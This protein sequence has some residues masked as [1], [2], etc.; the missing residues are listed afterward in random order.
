[1][2]DTCAVVHLD[3]KPRNVVMVHED[4]GT[5]WKLIDMDAA[6]RMGSLTGSTKT[7][8]A[9]C[10]PEIIRQKIAGPSGKDFQQQIDQKKSELLEAQKEDDYLTGENLCRELA[11]LQA[12]KNTV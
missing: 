8:T 5:A 3:T 10:S 6:N 9:Y 1:M 11:N 12:R 7:S 4:L 2:N